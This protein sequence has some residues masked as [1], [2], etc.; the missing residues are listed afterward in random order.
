MIF[1]VVPA[2]EWTAAGAAPYAPPSLA[3]E[4]FVHCSADPGAALTVANAHYRDA[5]APLLLV[6]IDEARLAAEVR[7]E[8]AGQAFPHVYGP[9]GREAVAEVRE[10]RRE[11]GAWVG[12]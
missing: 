12:P 10:L 9:I 1:H 2:P 5:P 3:A 6:G 11:A 4:G 8:G 7:W